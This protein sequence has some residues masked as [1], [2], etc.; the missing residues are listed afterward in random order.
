ME[1]RPPP[2]RTM[3]NAKRLTGIMG[4]SIAALCLTATTGCI[5]TLRVHRDKESGSGVES[6]KGLP[7]YVKTEQR[8]RTTTYAR[9]WREVELEVEDIAVYPTDGAKPPTSVSLSKQVFRRYVDPANETKLRQVEQLVANG[10]KSSAVSGFLA[11][12][13]SVAKLSLSTGQVANQVT[14]ATV[15][16]YTRTHYV[17]APLPWIGT[18]KLTPELAGDGTLNKVAVESEGQ[19]GEVLGAI[20]DVAETVVGFST[21]APDPDAA[22]RMPLTDSQRKAFESHSTLK[23]RVQ[24]VEE[25]DVFTKTYALGE[26]VEPVLGP[27]TPGVDHRTERVGAKPAP[28]PDSASNAYSFSGSVVPPKGK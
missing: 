14:S 27:A 26:T 21:P 5:N 4:A 20:F 19:V 13:D 24:W 12:P 16:D 25:R 2:I 23:L 11:L 7:F 6:A 1:P 18:S 15:V 22:N 28:K 10:D 8:T 9:A 17:N 3:P